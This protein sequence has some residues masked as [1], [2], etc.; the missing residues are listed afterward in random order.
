MGHR[1]VLSV[2]VLCA[3]LVGAVVFF[4][5]RSYV[6]Y[7]DAYEREPLAQITP[8][9]AERTRTMLFAGDTMLSRAVG[10]LMASRD[11]WEW[12]F[13]LIASTTQDADLMVL[14]LETPVSE[15][16]EAV[17]CGY[18]FRTD[19]RAIRGLVHAGVDVVTLANNHAF[20]YGS[21][22]L[23]DTVALLGQSG[24]AVSGAG[25]NR[26]EAHTA[27]IRQVGSTRVA[28]L[29]YTN[30]VPAAAGA[31]P[32]KPGV[33][34]YDSETIVHDIADA[35]RDADVVIVSF[36]A[37]DEYQAEPNAW[38]ERVYR[39]VID[40]GADVVIGHHP[41]VIQPVE[42]YGTG[43]IAYSLG[44]FVFDQSFSPETK[45]GLMLQV[46][47]LDG[48]VVGVLERPVS[49]SNRYQPA[50]AQIEGLR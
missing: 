23:T 30:L 36:H 25:L 26:D 39:S 1:Q 37:G 2:F 15:R 8:G 43:W 20:D 38:Q 6:V 31:G 47:V 33:A 22:A 49:I 4:G 5:L 29:S 32:D 45:R 12:P 44:N 9:D 46:S 21:D 50:L 40:A 3:A 35:R 27:V 16:G 42:S 34:I 10:D 11:D 24:I 17:G 28:L 18:C 19:P 41:H 13:A 14:N 7:S 48:R